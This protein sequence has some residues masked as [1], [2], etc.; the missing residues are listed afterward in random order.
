[1][2]A[3][4]PTTGRPAQGVPGPGGTN[5]PGSSGAYV[6]AAGAL[7]GWIIISQNLNELEP[8]NGT[9]TAKVL[10]ASP[11]I[12]LTSSQGVPSGWNVQVGQHDTALSECISGCAIFASQAV[13]NASH[14]SS[15]VVRYDDED[16]SHTPLAEQKNP[17]RVY[18]A[19]R[20]ERQASR[21]HHHRGS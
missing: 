20:V 4:V 15:R 2:A 14:S 3:P 11:T 6:A 10:D 9:L 1:M 18:G 21:P 7:S 17:L 19:V 12:V 16:W 13:P 5:A 8:A